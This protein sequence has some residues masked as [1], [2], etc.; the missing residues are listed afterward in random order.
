MSWY[1]GS[2]EK[3]IIS[4][5]YSVTVVGAYLFASIGWARIIPPLRKLDT[6][7]AAI[8]CFM[9]FMFINFC[10]YWGCYFY[11][12][13]ITEDEQTFVGVPIL[14]AQIIYVFIGIIGF[15][16]IEE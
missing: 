10:W 14:I 12:L 9:I 13:G 8:L 4:I 3:F 6:G 2:L 15:I 11:F 16:S 5:T 7:P 1:N